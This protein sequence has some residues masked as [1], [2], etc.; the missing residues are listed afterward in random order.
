MSDVPDLSEATHRYGN[1]LTAVR[2][3]VL[4]MRLAVTNAREEQASGQTQENGRGF[5]DLRGSRGLL[6][7]L[8]DRAQ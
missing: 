8:I 2:M 6:E 7:S 1:H 4:A 5:R 3:L